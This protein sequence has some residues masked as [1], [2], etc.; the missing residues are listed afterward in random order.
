MRYELRWKWIESKRIPHVKFFLSTFHH[1]T[2]EKTEIRKLALL[3]SHWNATQKK[4]TVK[5]NKT[6]SSSLYHGVSVLKTKKSK[7]VLCL[8]THRPRPQENLTIIEKWYF[9]VSIWICYLVVWYVFL[10]RQLCLLIICSVWPDRFFF[11]HLHVKYIYFWRNVKCENK[12]VHTAKLDR[13]ESR[14][15]IKHRLKRLRMLCS[16]P[17]RYWSSKAF[18]VYWIQH[19]VWFDTDALYNANQWFSDSK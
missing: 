10:L 1:Y 7:R 17:V 16:N 12:T 11:S 8:H 9:L 15:G 3:L 4:S 2:Q 6:V 14:N 19:F 13:F 18:Q 5:W